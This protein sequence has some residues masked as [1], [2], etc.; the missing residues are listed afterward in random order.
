MKKKFTLIF[1][2]LCSV[3]LI[4]ASLIVQTTDGVQQIHDI[5]R[6]GK[7]IFVDKDLQLLDNDGNLLASELIANIRKITFSSSAAAVD[8]IESNVI[9]VYPNPTQDMLFVKGIDTQSLRVYDLQGRI[10]HKE[11][12]TQITVSN[13]PTGTY[14]LQIGTQ[15]VRFIKH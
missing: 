1:A 11:D 15:V 2:I 3:E 6:I 14:L 5:A 13:L 12:G 8:N 7:W 4:A 10:L 9:V